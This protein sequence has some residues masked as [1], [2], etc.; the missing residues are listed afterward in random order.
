MRSGDLSVAQLPLTVA[1]L[2]QLRARPFIAA[3]S[4]RDL[5]GG[6]AA[7]QVRPD[8]VTPVKVG[9]LISVEISVTA[10]MGTN[11]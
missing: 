5:T 4:V 9:H 2:A 8:G 7:V 6:G 3:V 1:H 11:K 10:T